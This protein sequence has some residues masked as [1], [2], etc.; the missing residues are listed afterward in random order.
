MEQAAW[1]RIEAERERW[2]VLRHPF[3]QR[4]SAGELSAE[5]LA[6]YTGQ[7]RHAVNAIA[8]MSESVAT[9]LPERDDLARHASEERA[10]VGLWDSFLERAGGDAAAAA[11][12]ETAACVQVWAGDDDPVRTLAR[13]YA[14]ESGQPAISRT[15]LDGLTTH[16]GFEEGQGTA[17]FSLHEELDV[18]HAGEG[19]ELLEEL[20]GS[21]RDDEVVA[22]AS[23][24]F[25]ANWRLLDGV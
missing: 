22:A 9:A 15:K 20:A 2:N 23:A 17:Y 1:N 6:G 11:T 5:E 25:R 16:Y 21:G 4:W 18:E 8:G 19:R 24:A 7:Y 3:Y 13:L 12:P 10:H 14:V